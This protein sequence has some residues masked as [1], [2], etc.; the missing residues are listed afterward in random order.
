MKKSIIALGFCLLVGNAFAQ[1][2]GQ[3]SQYLNNQFILNPAAAGE[4]D[5]LDVDLSFRQQWVGFDNAPQNYY[6]SAH[7]PI[8][9]KETTYF[10]LIFTF[11]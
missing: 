7:T 3:Y 5:Y 11:E 9:K 8:G 1:Q 6:L 10:K 2:L 4:H